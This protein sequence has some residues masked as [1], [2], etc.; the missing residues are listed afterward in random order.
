[1]GLTEGWVR[2]LW[3]DGPRLVSEKD[4]IGAAVDAL[5]NE[6]GL[7]ADLDDAEK[8]TL[9]DRRVQEMGIDEAIEIVNHHSYYTTAKEREG[10]F[11]VATN[12]EY[13]DRGDPW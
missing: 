2:V 5:C 1:M 12:D 7:G 4:I 6:E 10:S 13:D 3:P 8:Q 11:R 9:I